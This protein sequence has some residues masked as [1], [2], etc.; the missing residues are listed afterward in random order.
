MQMIKKLFAKGFALTAITLCSVLLPLSATQAALIPITYNFTGLV[1][2]VSDPLS[3][4]ISSVGQQV[5][6]SF[7]VNFNPAA[8][9]GAYYGVITGFSINFNGT[10]YSA[11]FTPGGLINGVQLHN[12]GGNGTDSFKLATSVMGTEINDFDPT[13]FSLELK[14]KNMLTTDNLQP[15][16]L[17]VA[18]SKASWR[19]NFENGDEDMARIKGGF[20]H[21]TAV[22]LPAAVLLFGAGLISLVGLGAGGLRNLRGAKA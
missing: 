13:S 17:G 8:T 9:G 3:P 7:S 12:A 21:L 16:D 4:P 11:T 20:S 10:S 5:H 22:P 6:G 2:D 1:S 15:P 18:L 14:G 19:L